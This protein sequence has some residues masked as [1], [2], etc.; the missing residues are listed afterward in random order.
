MNET[1]IE[2]CDYSWNPVTGCKHHC[3]NVYCYNTMKRTSPLNRFGATYKKN[4][5]PIREANWKSRESGKTHVAEKGEI[6]PYG[7]DP[8]LYPHR[9]REPFKVKK[10]AK[11]F[12]VDAGDLFGDWVPRV[13]IE[14]VLVV[15]SQNP[16]HT[17][18]FL[19]KNPKRMLEFEFPEN[20]W[21]GTSVNT[22]RDR[23][24]AETVKK[25]TA[26]INWLSIEPLMGRIDFNFDDIQ[27]I[28]IGAQTGND[29]V[30]PKKVWIE[31]ITDRA[32]NLGI[33]VFIK[34]N[35]RPYYSGNFMQDFPV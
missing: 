16:Q 3:K 9:L 5:V 29:P 26:P 17:F 35:L 31:E 8:T 6:Y 14:N 20:A 34:N 32:E 10:P 1:K 23:N 13:W 7:F 24:I 22:S 28:V 25:V 18:Q 21:V 30:M 11:I 33:P 12:V 15:V 2:W 19:T 27:W 4:S